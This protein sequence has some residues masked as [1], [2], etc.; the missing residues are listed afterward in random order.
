MP[1]K[2]PTTQQQQNNPFQNQGEDLNGHFSKEDKQMASKHMRRCAALV[3]IRQMQIKA[4]MTCPFIL[5]GM[6]VMK[7]MKKIPSVAE[8]VEKLKP[9]ALLVAK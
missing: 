8:D 4:K 3:I 9:C 7:K 1:L 2:T 5:T 6:A